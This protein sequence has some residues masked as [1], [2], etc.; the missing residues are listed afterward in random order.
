[1]RRFFNGLVLGIILSAAGFWYVLVK[2]TQHPA[3]QPSHEATTL[4]PA[5]TNNGPA[6]IDL[7][8][9]WSSKLEVLDLNGEQIKAELKKSGEIVRRKPRDI[10]EAAV[11]PDSDGRAMSEIKGRYLADT[12]LSAWNI[13]V[14]CA[15]GHVTLIGIVASAD[16]IGKAVAIAL[17]ADGVRDVTSTLQAKTN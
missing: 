17:A 6:K 5:D 1:M 13:A 16:D 9:V 7:T 14:S 4:K 2:S 12:K 15:H 10:G 8:N 3:A 11:G